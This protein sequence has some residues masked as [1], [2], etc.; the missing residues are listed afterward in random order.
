MKLQNNN[1]HAIQLLE[2]LKQHR[3]DITLMYDEAISDYTTSIVEQ[4]PKDVTD[5]ITRQISAMY[6]L[7]E[8]L[9]RQIRQ[10][11]YIYN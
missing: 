2:V 8:D 7:H 11:S 5:T 4:Y 3:D 10:L 9:T 6:F 1:M